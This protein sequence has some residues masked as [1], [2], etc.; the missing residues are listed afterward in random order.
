[1]RSLLSLTILAGL[2]WCSFKLP[3]GSRTFAEHIDHIG[4]T[5]EAHQLVEGARG[6]VNPVIEEATS[7]LLGEYVEAPTRI[8]ADP[9]DATLAGQARPP[10]PQPQRDETDAPKLPGR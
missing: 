3:L 8:S 6:T 7:R 10:R 2:I 9:E 4:Q 1:V 5:P